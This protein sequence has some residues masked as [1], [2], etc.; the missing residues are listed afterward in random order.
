MVDNIS[1]VAAAEEVRNFTG[2]SLDFL[3]INGAYTNST[4]S[5]MMPTE[6][7]GK[8]EMLTSSMTESLKVNVLGV[9]FSI[10]AFLP[11]IRRSSIKKI[12][13]ISTAMASIEMSQQNNIAVYL[14]YSA[15][16]A[17]LNM[18]VTKFAVELKREGVLVLALGLGL[19]DTSADKPPRHSEHLFLDK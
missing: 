18:A 9:I 6:F 13:V 10:N 4:E 16:K 15:M 14:T 19:V 12:A 7:V 2:N 5:L 17:A 8:E 1:L 3:I 11:L